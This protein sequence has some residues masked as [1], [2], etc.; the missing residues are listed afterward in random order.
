MYK[1]CNIPLSSIF[2][3]LVLP[4]GQELTLGLLVIMTLEEVPFG[5][6]NTIPITS[7]I[8]KMHPGSRVPGRC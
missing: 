2:P 3:E 8:C 7:A 6:T 1:Y 4:S 5:H